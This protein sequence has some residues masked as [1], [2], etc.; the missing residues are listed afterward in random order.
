MQSLTYEPDVSPTANVAPTKSA[1]PKAHVSSRRGWACGGDGEFAGMFAMAE[2]NVFKRKKR[3]GQPC[4]TGGSDSPIAT[5]LGIQTVDTASTIG[6][7]SVQR[8]RLTAA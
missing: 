3:L 2:D 7:M 5:M 1:T 8:P 4:G 6:G